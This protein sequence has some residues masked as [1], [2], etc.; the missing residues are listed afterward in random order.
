M[1]EELT[2]IKTSEELRKQK[3][4]LILYELGTEVEVK[5]KII[6]EIIIKLQKAKKC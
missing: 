2:T 5:H 1:R 4:Y 6:S 3:I